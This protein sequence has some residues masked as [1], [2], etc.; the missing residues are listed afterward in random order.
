LKAVVARL[1]ETAVLS[2][3]AV[4]AAVVVVGVVFRKFGAALVW[5]DEVAS[6]LLA[7]LT[8]Y[9]AALAALRRAHIGV[10]TVVE[11]LEGRPRLLA[12]GI[13]E[14][15]VIGFFIVVAW[16]GWQV[17]QV[18]GGTTL[19]SLPWVPARLAQSVIPIGALLFIIAELLSVPEALAPHRA[20]E[21]GRAEP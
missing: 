15:A 16:A 6:I 10:P 5:Y 21:A 19:I 20:S 4:L 17:L 11:R 8:Y 9:G 18:L 13:A 3:I 14:T 1:L 7:W 12:V 2:L